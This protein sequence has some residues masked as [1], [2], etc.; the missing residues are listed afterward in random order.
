MFIKSLLKGVAVAVLVS[1]MVV[2]GTVKANAINKDT[3]AP[4][5]LEK[6]IPWVLYDMEEELCP[7]VFNDDRISRCAW[8]SRLN[9]S[10]NVDGGDF[11]QDWLVFADTW[12]VLPGGPGVWPDQVEVN[13]ERAVVVRRGAWPSVKLNKGEIRITGRFGWA[14][15][16]EMLPISPASGIVSLKIHGK[17]IDFPVLNSDGKLWLQKRKK[18]EGDEDRLDVRIQRLLTD[19]IPMT[20]A[21]LLKV[22]VSGRAREITLDNVLL[23]D[24]IP[25]SINS[26]LPARLENSGRLKL[27]A[28]PG[29]WEIRIK[30]RFVGPVNEIGPV[31]AVSGQEMW[32]FAAMNH[33][34]MVKVEGLVP[35]DPAQ[36]DL[37]DGWKKNPV[38]L[39]DPDA[40]MILKEVRRGDSDP[41]PDRL[42][43]R[44]AWWLDFDG[45]GFTIQD[46]ITGTMSRQWHLAMDK[47]GLLGRVS[48]DGKDQLITAQGL[49]GKPGVELRRGNLNL[50]ADSRFE[51]GVKEIP[52]VGWDHDFQ[53]VSA[54]LNLP[55][56]WRLLTASGVDVL[57]GT[58]FQQ[59][60]LLDFFIVLIIAI[61]VFKLSGWR[62]GLLAL[63][64][65]GLTYHEPG[66]PQLVWLNLLAALALL[67]VL[68]PGWARRLADLWRLA[69]IITLLVLAIPFIISQVRVGVYPQLDSP[70][71]YS[72]RY[73]G[74]AWLASQKMDADIMDEEGLD[75]YA[76]NAPME[77][78]KEKSRKKLMPPSPNQ[79]QQLAQSSNIYYRKK[80]VLAQ[81]PNAL[82]QT[83]PGLPTW[84]WRSI[85]MKW[86]GPVDRT[87]K[88]RL[89]L[90][91]PAVNLFLAI[92]R[93]ILLALLV[94][95]LI[96]LKRWWQGLDKGPAAAL[97]LAFLIASPQAA[98]AMTKDNIQPLT[99]GGP[100]PVE[101][102]ERAPGGSIYP[103]AEMLRELRDRLL[104]MPD[105]LPSCA[106]ISRMDITATEDNLQIMLE[107]HAAADTAVPLP[108]KSQSW[109]P[110]NVMMDLEPAEGLA[111]TRDG[112]LWIFAPK[113]LHTIV[114]TGKTPPGA[115]FQVP[116]SLKVGKTR[117]NS[118]GWEIS[119]L[120]TDGQ[121]EAS[122][123]FTRLKT[124]EGDEEIQGQGALPPFL[125]VERVIR[126][127]LTWEVETRVRR[128]T[129][130][131]NPVVVSIPLLKGESV[132]TGGIMVRQGKALINM[133]PST[134]QTQW[135]S[136]LD[137]V[138]ELKLEAPTGEPWIE[139][140][141]LD[142]GLIWHCDLDGIPVIHHQ[143]SEGRWRPQWRPWPGENVSIKVTRPK[144]V[145]GQTITVDSAFLELTPGER[146]NKAGLTLVIRASQ[147]GRQRVVLPE[148]AKLQVVRIKGKSQP[149]GQKGRD[150]L[151]PLQPGRQKI[152]V[153]WHQQ[154]D[155]STVIKGP[156][157]R[158]GEQGV[159]AKVTF[160][161]PSNRW[162]LW[163]GGPM[164]GPAVKFWSYLAVVI[165]AALGLGRIK[166]T[167]LKTRHWL[168]LSLGLTQIHPLMA[169]V[170]V[171]WVLI[172]GVREKRTPPDHWFVFDLAQLGLVLWTVVALIGL[173]TA[174][175]KGLL[176]I[177]HMQIA[178]N[179]SSN[180]QLNWTQDRIGA[181]MP[182]PFVLSL[183]RLVYHILMLLWALWLA[184]SLLKWLRW[185]WGAFGEGGLWKKW[186]KKRKKP[187]Q[188]TK[189]NGES[190]EFLIETVS[191]PPLN[192]GDEKK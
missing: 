93:V 78:R 173:Y 157:V 141:I 72:A 129:P 127:G 107:L 148:N 87:Q 118:Q 91:S 126:L 7:G 74:G 189:S 88:V 76:A 14:E 6:W 167:P 82:I 9:L 26:P 160:N 108:G 184:L 85:N 185:G 112:L 102:K 132:T 40:K 181:L 187:P 89:W 128:L 123:Q 94:I 101:V 135:T 43:L 34:R 169:I 73:P 57:P 84:K 44:R 38:Y 121:V 63:L 162:I 99:K 2:A 50:V 113:G 22:N 149:I 150:V 124:G 145:P 140:W 178:G 51:A 120:R 71:S 186:E 138:P 134:R 90:L 104:E 109:L 13:G 163:T 153:E 125:Q 177:P 100:P 159:N 171:G 5:E 131:G 172:L 119:G 33:L 45:R 54:V 188:M 158:I 42:N 192:G 8:P 116:L 53:S 20:A 37:P 39:V 35:V 103:S 137:I 49:D 46:K 77:K 143:D 62:L 27:Q 161:M 28:R 130:T 80:A 24:S 25:M 182:Q 68:P 10:V 12:V 144:A 30:S 174:V 151:I 97:V 105:C 115:S 180:F 19:G 122:L 170:I 67:R 4:G 66:A 164:L 154:T 166:W 58:W 175:E 190:G 179:Y 81:D 15:M 147:G 111:R 146:F 156:E 86:N 1:V 17:L 64:T 98:M 21:N 176:G 32:A 96:D 106:H 60:T 18:A 16:P 114:L 31:K 70:Y 75:D 139:S 69:S 133:G 165:L 36:T 168:L 117:I 23:P 183:P 191:P 155:S 55:P 61:A 3:G 59:W 65:V 29:R 95:A 83:G 48:V 142:A 152:Y 47:T 136:T 79:M 41:A 56:G 110:T 11:Q 52:A 92:V